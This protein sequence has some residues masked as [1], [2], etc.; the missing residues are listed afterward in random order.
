[1]R[2]FSIAMLMLALAS[3]TNWVVLVCGSEGFGNYRHH[4]DMLNPVSFLDI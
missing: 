1:M 3:A 4:A 2:L